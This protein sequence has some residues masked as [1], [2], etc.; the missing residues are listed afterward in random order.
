MQQFSIEYDPQSGQYY[1]IDTRPAA[2]H[3]AL[4]KHVLTTCGEAEDL[5]AEDRKRYTK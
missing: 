5:Q 3:T 2:I 4:H 1:V